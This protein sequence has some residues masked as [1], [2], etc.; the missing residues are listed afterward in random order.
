MIR[1]IVDVTPD[2]PHS[3]G[4]CPSGG[5]SDGVVRELSGEEIER[6]KW[7]R[8]SEILLRRLDRSEATER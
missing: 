3:A 4:I 2:V 1:R 8:H 7:E 6:I 5:L